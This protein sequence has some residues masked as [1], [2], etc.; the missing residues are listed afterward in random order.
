[1]KR[2]LLGLLLLV[3]VIQLKAQMV[4]D[5]IK[6]KTFHYGSATRDTFIQFPSGD[7]TYEKIIMKYNM[8]CKNALISNGTDRNLGCGEWDYSCNTYIVDSN[9]VEEVTATQPNY[10]IANF[11]G[12]N[13]KYTTKTP[14]DYYNYTQQKV[15]VNNITADNQF[16]VASG[17]LPIDYL[18]KANERSG[19]SQI[20]YRASELLM[21]GLTAG[22]IDGL[23]LNVGNNGGKA[24][25][26][27]IK[28]KGTQVNFLSS[29]TPNLT[30]FTEVLNE[31]YEFINGINTIRFKKSFVWDG[32][33]NLIIEYSYTNTVPSNPIQLIG[34]SDSLTVGLYA[35]NNYA[36][37]LMNQG[38]VK[39]DASNLAEISKELTISFWAF[40][41]ASSMPITTSILYGFG[42]NLNE[43]QL[44]IHL[45]HS[46]N[47]VYFDCGF[48]AG[49]YDRINKIATAD[50][51][52][53]KWNH[54]TF[55]KNATTGNMKIFLNGAM[56][57]SGTGK[58]KAISIL[59]LLLGKDQ[60][61]GSNYKGKIN[62][63]AIWKKEMPD[64][65]ILDWMNKP[66]NSTHPLYN[67][68]LSYYP[69]NEGT[70]LNVVNKI[71]NNTL[72]GENLKWTYDRGEN[73][74]RTFFETNM[75]PSIQFLRSNYSLSIQNVVVKDSIA[76]STATI[77]K[78]KIASKAGISPLASDIVILDTTY[79]N[80][81][82]ASISKTY[83]GDSGTVTSSLPI[84]S[85]G[86]FVI[87]N[88]NYI[89]R[90]PF[91]NEI[92]SFVTPYGIGLDLGVN[93][94]NW[95]FDVSDFAPLLKGN[96][97]ILMTLGGQNQEQND[98][99]FWF[100][101]G[102]PV[103][104]VLEFNQLW[105]GT[106]RLGA[107][108]IA[109]INNDTKFPPINVPILN[110]GKSFKIRSSITGHGAEG[111][112][113]SN[114][115]PIDH[116]LKINNV[117]KFNWSILQEC[118]SNPVFPQ[119]GT[120]IYDRQGWCPGKSSLLKEH[121]I[122]SMVSPGT[123]VNFDYNT[124]YP[125]NSNGEYKYQVAHQLVTYGEPNF[126]LDA[127]IIDVLNPSDKIIN[128]RNNPVCAMPNMVI[129]NT[130]STNITK[131]EIS[132]WINNANSKQSFTWIGNLN[133][134]DTASISLPIGTLWNNGLQ[135]KDNKFYAQ[136][137]KV[138]NMADNYLSNNLYESPFNKPEVVT[139]NFIIELR[140]N[141]N[142]SENS[143][144]LLDENGFLVDFKV[145]DKANTV[146]S[147]TYNLGGCYTLV[148]NDDGHDGLSFWA[149]SAQGTGYV[150][151]K[152][153]TGAVIK[154]L[155]PDFGSGIAYGFTTN[156]TLN[157]EE[158]SLDKVIN[159]YPNPTSEK[160]ILEGEELQNSTIKI[161]DVIG[162]NYTLP[163]S[164]YKNTIEFNSS[165]LPKGV[166]FVEIVKGENKTV[167]SL[168]IQ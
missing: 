117:E 154:T 109:T 107:A 161:Y 35:N 81:Y 62:E 30:G 48:A 124:S 39:L 7:L 121:N 41:N 92:M 61:N 105:Q 67:Q 75:R 93:G 131:L 157:N 150:R 32:I 37:D 73:L 13:F 160:F 108:V 85:E 102:T 145:F 45:P 70:G 95:Y 111:E 50:E 167:K 72:L 14:Y 82:E 55:T 98:V 46:S 27:K 140:T 84:T 42:T 164:F 135:A 49:G 162:K 120:W 100:I 139:S 125:S 168:V 97:R 64:S 90:Y 78:Y 155:Q 59:N 99:E 20:L 53:G 24:G 71:T 165:S 144:S 74:N 86:E 147:T 28:I 115:G 151:V 137:I 106:N 69:F 114:G 94:K 138:N 142:P 23:T 88:L 47:N 156:W 149:N 113:E 104:N 19:K 152:K 38:L 101:V 83:N 123:T 16:G 134:L 36:L 12:T 89:N 4:G 2:N 159:L 11:T 119:G 51:Q 63:L 146:Y 133:F 21:A 22:N 76:K 57:F 18:L 1:M 129:Q 15:S 143:Y 103:R 122:T 166:Y 148:V 26:L 9:K 52:G 29:K 56:W 31:D 128:A 79:S 3:F 5:T 158:Y 65:L 132:Y 112:F 40:G 80:Y 10:V 34:T 25:F 153:S 91:Y 136:I 54:W 43:R 126:N 116:K 118:A 96:K 6:V 87:S 44:N 163:N 127:R 68:L 58:T 8:R 110:N 60:A 141:N 66:L 17:N 130:G 33:Q 77:Q